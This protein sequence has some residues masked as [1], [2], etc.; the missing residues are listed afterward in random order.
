MTSSV[1]PL[2]PLIADRRRARNPFFIEEL[3]RK[4]DE[5]GHLAGEVGAYRLLRAPDMRLI[6]DNVQAIVAAR[7]DSRPETERTLAADG[8]CHWPR[9]HGTHPG[10]CRSIAGSLVS[11]ALHRLSTA[12]L[13]Y[14]DRRSGCRQL[15]L[16]TSDGAGSGLPLAGFS[17][18]RHT[19]HASVA[20]ELE[21]T[22]PDPGGAQAGFIAYHLE[23]AGNVPQAASYNMK[24]AMWHGTRDPAQALDA[25]KRV[26]PAPARLP[27]RDRALSAVDGKRQI[28][29][30]Y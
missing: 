15:R 16:Q 26:R 2:L 10:A 14:E 9:I 5:S 11:A 13:V 3:V 12:G 29:F 23:E 22:L 18:R 4:F 21:K 24:A 8:R 19:L 27:L 25:W 1:T 20:A 28:V 6:P 30:L 7:V 17:D